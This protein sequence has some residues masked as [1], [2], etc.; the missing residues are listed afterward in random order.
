MTEVGSPV[1]VEQE[2]DSLAVHILCNGR[3]TAPG[4]V[5]YMHPYGRHM[6]VDIVQNFFLISGRGHVALVDTGLDNP[7]AHVDPADRD[8]LGAGRQTL[9]LLSERSITPDQVDTLILTHLHHDHYANAQLFENARIILNRREYEFVMAPGNRRALPRSTFP[10]A[11]FGWLADDAWDRLE[12]VDGSADVFDGVRVVETR[13]HSPGHQI[14]VVETAADR[15]V[16]PG[17]EIYTYA[18][19][20]QDI[21]IGY[22]HDFERLSTSMDLIRDLGG[23]VLPAHDGAV[24]DRHPAGVIG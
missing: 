4:T 18:N 11:V 19:L 24:M 22:Y 12:L 5:I 2:A 16:I 3:W 8:R 15:V 9:E 13:G 7:S 23:Q 17:D 10:R 1:A 20:E 14:V 21:P 6:P